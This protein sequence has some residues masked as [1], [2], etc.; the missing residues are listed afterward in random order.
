ME[1]RI[2]QH[3]ADLPLFIKMDEL[4]TEG[5]AVREAYFGAG[6]AIILTRVEDILDLAYVE[7][8]YT[9]IHQVWLWYREHEAAAYQ[10]WFGMCSCGDLCEPLLIDRAW[11]SDSEDRLGVHKMVQH[12]QAH[13]FMGYTYD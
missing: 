9:A 1:N 5:H 4:Q 7:D 8:D 2:T 3:R 6:A 12:G 10:V 11:A 13:K